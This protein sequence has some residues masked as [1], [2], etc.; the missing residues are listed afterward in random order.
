MEERRGGKE[1]KRKEVGRMRKG[2]GE[3]REGKE[4]ELQFLSPFYNSSIR[5]LLY[6]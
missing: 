5:C 4:W 3:E 1:E 6:M 2:T